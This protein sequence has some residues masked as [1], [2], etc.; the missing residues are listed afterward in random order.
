MVLEP[1]YSD[2]KPLLHLCTEEPT[3]F[4]NQNLDLIFLQDAGRVTAQFAGKLCPGVHDPL[5]I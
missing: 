3:C 1:R 4:G 5:A 2:A